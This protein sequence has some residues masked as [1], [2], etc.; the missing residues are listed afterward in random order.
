MLHSMRTLVWQS[1]LL[2]HYRQI[3]VYR[4]VCFILKAVAHQRLLLEE[5]LS[6]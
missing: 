4:T 1:V 3:D 5:K 2:W 6:P